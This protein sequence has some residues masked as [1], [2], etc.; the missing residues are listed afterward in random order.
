VTFLKWEHYSRK[1]LPKI[2]YSFC[3]R[4]SIHCSRENNGDFLV[5]EPS[6]PTYVIPNL[7]S[8]KNP[9]MFLTICNHY[10]ASEINIKV[11]PLSLCGVPSVRAERS[12]NTKIVHD[13]PISIS[14][15]PVCLSLPDIFHRLL[16][17]SFCSM[18]F[19]CVKDSVTRTL[20]L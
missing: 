16:I 9:E 18:L 13:F 8:E 19:L 3:N 4:S 1:T 20:F 15:R 14:T 10:D 2:H 17:L 6:S 5:A 12:F 11:T 7:R